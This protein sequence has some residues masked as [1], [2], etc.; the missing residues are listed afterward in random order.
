MINLREDWRGA[1]GS[2]RTVAVVDTVAE[3]VTV[4][5]ALRRHGFAGR[6]KPSAAPRKVTVSS[7][8]AKE[9]AEALRCEGLGGLTIREVVSLR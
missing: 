6:W 5:R 9:A 4:V 1:P 3:A 8:R 7:E 2:R